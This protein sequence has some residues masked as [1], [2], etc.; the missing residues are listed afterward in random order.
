M[1]KY[2]KSFSENCKFQDCGSKASHL[3]LLHKHGYKIPSGFCLTTDAFKLMFRENRLH[4]LLDKVK[5]LVMSSENNSFY[6]QEIQTTILNSKLPQ[7]L[8][9]EL[10]KILKSIEVKKVAIR[11]SAICEDLKDFSYAGMFETVLDVQADISHVA[12]GIKKV[13]SSLFASKVLQYS[14]E[15]KNLNFEF[16]MGVIVQEMILPQK[17]G[18]AFSMH[19]VMNDRTVIYIEETSSRCEKIVAGEVL[20][21][22]YV[23]SKKDLS[24]EWENKW[25][26]KLSEQL[27]EIEDVFG[28]PVDVEWALHNDDIYFL[29]VR[30]ITTFKRNKVNIWTDDNVGEVL[31]SVVTPLTWSILGSLT[32]DSFHWILHQLGIN[33]GNQS[34][35]FRLIRGKAYF[36]S[37][38]FEQTLQKIYPSDILRKNRTNFKLWEFIKTFFYTISI[39]V[40]FIFLLFWLPLLS[41]QIEKKIVF[42]KEPQFTKDSDHNL[43]LLKLDQILQ[44]QRKLMYLHVANTFLGEIFLQF[45]QRIENKLGYE[46]GQ[47]RVLEM[48]S[49]IGQARS[50]S[51]GKA[52]SNMADSMRNYLL[53]HRINFKDFKQFLH[54]CNT[55]KVLQKKVNGFLDNYGY[56]S[57]QEFEL[58]YPRWSEEPTSLLEVLHK[59][60]VHSEIDKISVTTNNM[61]KTQDNHNSRGKS[62]LHSIILSYPVKVIKIFNRNRENL[63]QRFIEVHFRMKKL[64]LMISD[65]FLNEEFLCSKS[66]IFF[67]TMNQIKNI[68]ANPENVSKLD[69]KITIKEN[70]QEYENRRKVKHPIKIIE[71]NG[72][73]ES[74]SDLLVSD[75]F[76]RR[77]IPCSSGVVKGIARV[78]NNFSEAERFKKN[79][80]LITHSANPGW[81][82]LFL[83][84]SGVLTEIGGALSHS[85]IIAREYGVPMIASVSDASKFIK[86]GELIQMDG[87]AGVVRI[88]NKKKV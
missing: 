57:D 25:V 50:A 85:A 69:T 22:T 46:H 63:K 14:S 27:L 83:L 51:G 39:V 56:M 81:V 48:I 80:I 12:M 73:F 5:K 67:I 24:Q 44:Y 54:L 76:S 71:T 58:S 35:F 8:T 40:R 77:G 36:N 19:P 3:S 84:A 68:L 16:S 62:R 30:S 47:Q 78:I 74:R 55:D 15:I 49:N 1:S 20:P 59:L 41:R 11:S 53:K 6:F 64:L 33:S 86:T 13:W 2:I 32:N 88:I 45:L 70:K 82:P 29:Q 9:L 79:E 7:R 21:E 61:E 87:T 26:K 37:T 38:L 43:L 42:Y 52:L 31:P 23:I 4:D 18:V 28:M 17:S 66:D 75:K 10:E 34:D 65:L 72:K 60:I